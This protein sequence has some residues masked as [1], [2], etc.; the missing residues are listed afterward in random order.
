M[1]QNGETDRPERIIDGGGLWQGRLLK[2]T[3]L[4]STNRWALSH[5]DFCRHG[6]VVWAQ[7]QTAGRGR[8]DRPWL[9]PGGR[10]LT[11]SFV[12][13]ESDKKFFQAMGQT[14][15]LAVRDTL[16]NFSINAQ[17]KWPNDVLIKGNKI[18]GIL[19][20]VDF[21]RHAVVL[22]VGLNVNFDRRDIESGRINSP[23][24]SMRIEKNRP[25]DIGE[26]R[27]CLVQKM[28]KNCDL[29]VEKGTSIIVDAWRQSD[30]LMGSRIRITNP[31]F[32]IEGRYAGLDH[33]GQLRLVDDQEK[34]NRFLA[35]DVTRLEICSSPSQETDG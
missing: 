12:F 25:V 21:N 27:Q 7:Y 6:D 31:N 32:T 29:T 22:G 28:E 8:F 20:E 19:S 16:E 2:F 34:E 35:G 4:E 9:S 24:T 15:A 11:L 18:A 1:Q 3:R 33:D 17:L 26:V 13:T 30:W 10:G 14:A 5:L 23:A